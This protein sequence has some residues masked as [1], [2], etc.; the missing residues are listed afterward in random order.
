MRI[1][2]EKEIIL[3]ALWIAIGGTVVTLCLIPL[4]WSLVI[5]WIAGCS[6]AIFTTYLN[7]FLSKWFLKKIKTKTMGF[8]IWMLIFQFKLMIH[9]A[10][11]IAIIA[12]CKYYND[13]TF[14]SGG[15]STM[16]DPINI[17]TYLFGIGITV[18]STLI[19]NL[20]HKKG[21]ANG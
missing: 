10:L 7:V 13:E 3:M 11:F 2:F 5:G 12:I 15:I 17:F 18:T 14:S 4:E 20:L 21:S 1:K 9:A 6:A 8:W 16:Y 19:V